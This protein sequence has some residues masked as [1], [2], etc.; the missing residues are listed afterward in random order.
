MPE[1]SSLPSIDLNRLGGAALGVL[2][3]NRLGGFTRPAIG[4]YPHQWSWDSA[5]IAIGLRHAEPEAARSELRSLVR[6]QWSDGRLPQIVYTPGPDDR[7]QPGAEFWAS[8]RP[9][10]AATPSAG[11][12]QPPVHALAAL[13]VADATATANPAAARAFERELYP[14]LRQWHDYLVRD[15][16]RGRV[17]AEIVHPWESGTDNLPLWDAALERIPATPATVITR[18]DLQHA[19]LGE[20]PG[21]REYAKFFWLA[22]EYRDG[23]CRDHDGLSFRLVDPLFNTLWAVSERALAVIAE[24]CGEDPRPHR[25]RADAIERALDELWTGDGFYGA[26]DRN[27]DTLID[28]ATCS[29]LIPLLLS[30][31]PHADAL[32]A[33]LLGERFLGGPVPARLVP[34]YDRTAGDFDSAQYWR[35]PAWI[36]MN[37]MLALA[38]RQSGDAT[39]A[40]SLERAI[41]EAAAN[42]DPEASGAFPEYVDPVTLEARGT[43]RFSWTAALT[44]DVLAGGS[45]LPT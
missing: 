39:T 21:D 7:Y 3:A 16:A 27:T 35:G 25:E 14:A 30:N 6:G 29:G 12:I 42:G 45:R 31:L 33:T 23:A 2:H 26:F 32:R 22:E 40:E 36:N 34:S 24:R 44:L 38:L 5:F 11:L 28:R 41:L 19:G 13:L 17:L 10:G 9:A 43:R 4:L 20:R 1:V 18:P 15:R 37:W 8:A